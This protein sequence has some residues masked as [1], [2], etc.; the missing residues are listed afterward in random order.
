MTEIICLGEPMVEFNQNPD[1][2][3]SQGF[4]GDTSNCAISAARQGANVSYAT[5]IGSDQFGDQLIDLWKSEGVNTDLVIRDPDF[6]TAVYF[7]THDQS[8][9]HYTYY[10][11]HSAVSQIKPDDLPEPAIANA[12]LLHVS[13]ISQAISES[14]ADTVLAA[15]EIANRNQTTVAYDTNLRLNLWSLDRAKSVIHEAMAQC[16]IALPSYDD[17]TLLTG[18]T[19]PDDIVDFY[20][21]LGASIVVLKNGS[22]GVIVATPEVRRA[23]PAIKVDFVDANGAGDTFAGAFHAAMSLGKDHFDA[24][25]Y[26]NTAAGLSTTRPGAVTAIPHKTEVEARLAKGE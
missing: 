15:I 18:F 25:A 7:V 11:K 8:G 1:G 4:G 9:H 3:F 10:R 17:A 12:R 26:A 5:K 14:A 2:R 13:A 23:I 24:A 6:P 19:E 16:Q 22:Q 21:K 20:L